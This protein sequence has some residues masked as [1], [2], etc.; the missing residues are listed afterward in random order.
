[1]FKMVDEKVGGLRASVDHSW[2]ESDGFCIRHQT[3]SVSADK[4][5]C[6]NSWSLFL[7]FKLFNVHKS[8]R[9][10]V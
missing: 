2:R 6:F 4:Q 5:P 3:E 9:C 1:M 10:D 7:S 8:N